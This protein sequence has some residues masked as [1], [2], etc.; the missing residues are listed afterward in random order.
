MTQFTGKTIIITGASSGLGRAI[1]I[2]LGSAVA[3]LWLTGRSQAELNVTASMVVDAGG[4]PPQTRAIDLAERGPLAALV[5]EAA[6]TSDHLFALINNA[7]LMFPEPVMQG[8]VDRWTAMLSVNVLAVLEG[9]QAAVAVMRTHG[10]PGHIINIGSVA[11]R[12]EETG[13]YGATKKMVENI[14]ASLRGE[15][16]Q[17]DIRVTT[18]VPG[19]F[20]TQ[21]AR[22]FQ[23]EQLA[24][25]QQSFVQQ[26]IGPDGAGAHRLVSDPVHLA[27]AVAYV[28]EQP[29]D[30]NIQ[31]LVIRPPV[32]TGV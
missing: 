11:A 16:E 31:E 5:A 23:A 9:A 22:G 14:T 28:L 24:T 25:V 26:G 30:I 2:R 1:A 10:K 8:S 32:A 19:G 7:G 21:L 13:V 29:I 27:N 15:T 12:W 20:A 4:P 17:D 18:I 6:G 3:D